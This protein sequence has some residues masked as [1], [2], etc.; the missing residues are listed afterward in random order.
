MFIHTVVYINKI[1]FQCVKNGALV[2]I[3]YIATESIVLV[4]V[5]LEVKYRSLYVEHW[6][7]YSL[8]FN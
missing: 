2:V 4:I 3:N 1:S 5:I 8:T 7:A 6:Y